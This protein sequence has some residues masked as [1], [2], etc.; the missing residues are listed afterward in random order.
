M[1][2]C[3]EALWSPAERVVWENSGDEVF[4]LDTRRRDPRPYSLGGSGAQIWLACAE[5]PQSAE[6][7][8]AVFGEPARASEIIV[9]LQQ[10]QNLGM[11]RC[12]EVEPKCGG[13]T[14]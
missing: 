13:T 14:R 12:A 9:F 11:M 5:A 1:S 2:H 7:L 8:S 4:V 3:S 10:L 6:A